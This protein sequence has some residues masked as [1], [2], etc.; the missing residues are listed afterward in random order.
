M[1]ISCSKVVCWKIF[2]VKF[3]IQTNATLVNYIIFIA[4][5]HC[6]V[7]GELH[8]I[9]LNR[10][11]EGMTDKGEAKFNS[12]FLNVYHSFATLEIILC[13]LM[14]RFRVP[15]DYQ[16]DIKFVKLKVIN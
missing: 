5:S 4:N 14:E 2:G 13:K 3:V 10:L 6:L 7:N 16:G 15:P 8:K 1:T 12:H 11:I 9:S